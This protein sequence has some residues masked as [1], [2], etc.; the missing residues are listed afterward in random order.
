MTDKNMANFKMQVTLVGT[1]DTLTGSVCEVTQVE[2]DYS[3]TLGVITPFK[4]I[5]FQSGWEIM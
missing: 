4:N 2:T 5:L 3:F 1:V